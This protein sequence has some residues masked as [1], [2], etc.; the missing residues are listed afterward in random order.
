MEYV[1]LFVA[2]AAAVS[3]QGALPGWQCGQVTPKKLAVV[4]QA[5]EAPEKFF[6]ALAGKGTA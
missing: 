3:Y 1:E 2:A 5:G 6:Q 4:L